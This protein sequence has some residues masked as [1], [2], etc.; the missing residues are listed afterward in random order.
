[1]KKNSLVVVFSIFCQFSFGQSVGVGQWKDYLSYKSGVCVTEGGGKA[2]CATK[3]GIFSLNV[4]DNSITRMSKVSGLADVEAVTLNYNK[5]NDKLIIAYKNSNIDII[6]NSGITNLSDIKRKS[7]LGN[8]SINSIYFINQYAYLA[9]GFG[10]VVI[11]MDKYEVSDT[12]YIGPNGTALNVRDITSDS[13]YFYVATD[14]G[15]YTAQKHNPNLA[16]YESW[17][18]MPGLPSGVYNT[19]AAFDDKVFTNFSQAVANNLYYADSAYVYQNG[20]WNYFL[21]GS[22]YTVR[23]MRKNGNNLVVALATAIISYDSSL[24]TIDYVSGY[25]NDNARAEFAVKDALGNIWIADD[26]YGMVGWRPGIGTVSYLPDGPSSTNVVVMDIQGNNLSVAPGGG[27]NGYFLDGLYTYNGTSWKNTRGNFPSIVDLDSIFNINNVLVDPN[28]SSRTFVATGLAGVIEFSNAE[29]V[30]LYNSDN[31]SLSKISNTGY[32]PVWTSGL[33]FDGNSNLWVGNSGVPSSLSVMKTDGTWQAFNFSSFI[34]NIPNIG[35]ILVDKN[36]QKWIV[37]AR[38]GG[39]MVFNGDVGAT[40]T[41][42]NT[43]KMTIATGN[44]AL[45]STNVFCVAEDQDGQIWMGTDKGIAVFYSPENMFSGDNF[46]CQQILIEQDG[47]VQILFETELIQSIA[48]DGA[49]R[50]WIATLNSGVF[51]MSP[52]GT[53]QIHHFD[54]TNSPLFSNDVKSVVINKQTGEVFFGTAKGIISYRGT[55]TA[56]ADYFTDVYAFPNPVKHSY[57]G[58]IAIKGLVANSTVKITDL[59]GRLVY[60]T[61][62]D[63]GQAIWNGKTFSGE[64]VSSGVY[65]VFCANQDGTQQMATKILFIN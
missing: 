24:T 19:I 36:N 5:Y 34:G 59:S 65:M 37:L 47:H 12:Y 62:S 21:P 17:A 6:D 20:A 33:A 23:S 35:Q 32:T 45:P 30:K 1:M 63:G 10:I 31:S 51:L 38:G 54:I 4:S 50:K 42:S 39:L 56:G 49:N 14:V 29:P 27:S 57:D 16:N 8:K 55:A 58:P 15:I 41:T 2:Y 7:I 26:K 3:S 43:K 64:R 28:N 40:P 61:V 48:V 60:E 9:C 52:D 44:G 25:L 46:D 18:L 13:T 11:D 22:G 53:K